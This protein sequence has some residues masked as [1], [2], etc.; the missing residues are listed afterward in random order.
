MFFDSTALLGGLVASVITKWDA[1]AQF[2]YGYVRAEVLAGFVNGLFLLFIAFF[3]LSESI[4]RVIDP[5]DVKH[6]RLLLISAL[7]LVVNVMGLVCFHSG[8]HSHEGVCI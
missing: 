1:N 6:E 2:S 4:E 7:G 3:I 8:E 5:P